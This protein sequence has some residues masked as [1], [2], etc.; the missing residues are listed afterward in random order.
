MSRPP[1]ADKD[2]I[3][4]RVTRSTNIDVDHDNGV[5]EDPGITL[6][7]AL[8]VFEALREKLCAR[9]AAFRRRGGAGTLEWGRAA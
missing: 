3:E 1:K 5:D 8:R 4:D 9:M 2:D 6:I 7:P